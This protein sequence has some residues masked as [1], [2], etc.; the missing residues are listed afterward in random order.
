MKRRSVLA[1]CLTAI[2]LLLSGLL[3]PPAG[4]AQSADPF[5]LSDSMMAAQFINP[6]ADQP[7]LVTSQN[8]ASNTAS[9][10]NLSRS[11]YQY[12]TSGSISRTETEV[13]QSGT[14]VKSSLAE[15]TYDASGNRT[16]TVNYVWSGSDWEKG[17]RVQNIYV[18][19][20]LS[21]EVYE[22][23]TGT[24]WM[25][26]SRVDHS[27]D[28]S[29]RLSV[30][31]TYVGPTSTPA[32][33]TTFTYEGVS[34]RVSEEVDDI[35]T[36]SAWEKKWRTD[37]TYDPDG[38]LETETDYEWDLTISDWAPLNRYLSTYNAEGLLETEITQDW[39]S[40]TSKWVNAER[41][42]NS[43]VGGRLDEMIESSWTGTDWEETNRT[44]VTYD[45]TVLS[46][47]LHQN[48]ESNQWVNESRQLFGYGVIPVELATFE[49]ARSGASV[50]LVWTTAS[51]TNN[52]GFR[53]E[54]RIAETE[55]FVSLGFVNG[56][57]TTSEP[58][59]YQFRDA[60][61]KNVYGPVDY[62]LK[63]VD[64]D[65]TTEYS[66]TIRVDLGHPERLA[67]KNLGANPVSLATQ[68]EYNL[69]REERVTL[70]VYNVL[71][72]EVAALVNE[73]Q[74]PGTHSVEFDPAP[75]ST[76]LYFLQLRAGDATTIEGI[77][78]VR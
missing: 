10:E 61:L 64:L 30:S 15:N 5:P 68:L 21:E 45:G 18:R 57:G 6:F 26:T 66:P 69:P 71:G 42:S 63:Q 50:Q 4:L 27:Y 14:W 76:G 52:A 32:R 56:R 34:N 72:Q 22:S 60:D 2:A 67:F 35:W 20:Q 16:E 13:R 74:G 39:D 33:R 28:G 53:V 17:T 65:G 73:R 3:G 7:S 19:G 12:T 23:W 59:R 47:I 51:E 36:G 1:P 55:A 9:W 8:W 29:D 70:R 44:V 38:L 41:T 31:V 78:V 77:S 62:R 48:R 58:Q 75:F 24:A 37:Y 43:Y 40:A 46:E 25:V 49:A 11:F 54:R